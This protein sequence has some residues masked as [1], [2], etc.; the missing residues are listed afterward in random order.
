MIYV[1]FSFHEFIIIMPMLPHMINDN[2]HIRFLMLRYQRLHL[3]GSKSLPA[4][5]MLTKWM[6]SRNTYIPQ[7]TPFHI[8]F[9]SHFCPSTCKLQTPGLG[10][11]GWVLWHVMRRPP[12]VCCCTLELWLDNNSNKIMCWVTEFKWSYL[13]QMIHKLVLRLICD[14]IDIYSYL[15]GMPSKCMSSSGWQGKWKREP[16]IMTSDFT[17]SFPFLQTIRVFTIFFKLYFFS[18]VSLLAIYND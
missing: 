12:F 15:Y 4:F 2:F 11:L 5:V 17:R 7:P 18:R 14:I 13:G 6:G 16:F 1:Q 8:Q 3:F 10:G 9:Q